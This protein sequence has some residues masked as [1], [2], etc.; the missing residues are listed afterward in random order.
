MHL[1]N[2][3]TYISVP[4]QRA[5][6]VSSSLHSFFGHSQLYLKPDVKVSD[7]NLEFITLS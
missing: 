6:A 2:Q 5:Y 7:Q 4:T 1:G 3:E